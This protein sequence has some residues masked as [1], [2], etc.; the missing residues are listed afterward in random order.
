M[1]QLPLAPDRTGLPLAGDHVLESA[2]I[3][4]ESRC[5][6][7]NLGENTWVNIAFGA[8]TNDTNSLDNPKEISRYLTI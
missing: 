3:P 7:V 2:P 6:W 8:Q 5:G 1:S 4:M